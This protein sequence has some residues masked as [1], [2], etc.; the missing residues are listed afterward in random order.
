MSDTFDR[1][2]IDVGETWESLPD[3]DW[4][5]Y[6]NAESITPGEEYEV[7]A[8]VTVNGEPR[9]LCEFKA[10]GVV[11]SLR[12]IF[13]YVQIGL[14]TAKPPISAAEGDVVTL[15][16]IRVVR[17]INRAFVAP[18]PDVVHRFDDYLI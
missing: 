14:A 8:E 18:G 4:N 12:S 11:P 2:D 5:A 9:G 15:N 10:V 16:N 3:I 6:A 7:S 17:A 1:K 13:S